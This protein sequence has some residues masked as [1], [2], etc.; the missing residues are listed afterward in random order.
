MTHPST[1]LIIKPPAVLEGVEFVEEPTGPAVPPLPEPT[2]IHVQA[3]VALLFG[4]LIAAGVG[5]HR[6]PDGIPWA[7][8]AVVAA[9]AVFLFCLSRYDAATRRR[10]N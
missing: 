8:G 1:D 3:S 5:I 10:G 6:D 9:L 7:T 2:P 4:T